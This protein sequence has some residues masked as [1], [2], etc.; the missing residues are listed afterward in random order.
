MKRKIRKLR[1]NKIL[2]AAT[3]NPGNASANRTIAAAYIPEKKIELGF[4]IL[5][6]LSSLKTIEN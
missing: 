2:P 1:M 3:C 4:F 6:Q 5:W